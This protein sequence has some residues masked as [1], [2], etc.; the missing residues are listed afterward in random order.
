MPEY[1]QTMRGRRNPAPIRSC[2]PEGYIAEHP[3]IH[4]VATYIDDGISGKN[5]FTRPQYNK[6]LQQLS[7]NGFD[8]IITKA[9]SRLNRDELNSLHA[10]QSAD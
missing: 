4:L 1:Q 6:M 8:L 2:L 9:L 10:E 7:E 3:N 5:D